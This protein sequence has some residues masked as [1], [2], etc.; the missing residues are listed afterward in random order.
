MS[1]PEP[2]QTTSVND[3]VDRLAELADQDRIIAGE[4]IDAFGTQ[5]F[6]PLLMIPALL[7]VSPLSGIPLFSSVCG[8]A[9]AAISVQMVAGRQSMWLPQFLLRRSL[10]G[11]RARDAIEKLHGVAGW[12][13]HHS[14][15]RFH[16]LLRW[17]GRKLIHVFCL[18]C[19][20]AMPFLE[21]VPFSSSV[22]GTAVLLFATALLLRD[23]LFALFGM[24]AMSSAAAIL[25]TVAGSL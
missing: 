17:P 21:I 16:P 11:Q 8:I 4:I 9:I 3:I 25:L 19:G 20:S 22:L 14:R 13:D 12:L 7:V 2:T 18:L 1:E 6:L 23:G 24:V 5:S 15:D 10:E